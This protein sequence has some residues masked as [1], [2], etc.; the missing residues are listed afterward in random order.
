[1]KNNDDHTGTLTVKTKLQKYEFYSNPKCK[2]MA[3]YALLTIFLYALCIYHVLKQNKLK[4]EMENLKVEGA[5]KYLLDLNATL[6]G[7]IYSV[8]KTE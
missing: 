3:P 1:L 6:I 8:P 4:D 7:A 5:E 2:A